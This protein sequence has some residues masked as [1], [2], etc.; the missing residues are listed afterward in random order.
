MAADEDIKS[1]LKEVEA[2]LEDGDKR[3]RQMVEVI[4]NALYVYDMPFVMYRRCL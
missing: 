4:P 2:I 1:Q 3:I